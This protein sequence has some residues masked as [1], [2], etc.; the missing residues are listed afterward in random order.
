MVRLSLFIQSNVSVCQIWVFSRRRRRTN[1][2]KAVMV[3]E[4]E[5]HASVSFSL[6]L[7]PSLAQILLQTRAKI[8]V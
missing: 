7:F 2:K 4:K 8:C 1:R 6:S 5:K 3:V